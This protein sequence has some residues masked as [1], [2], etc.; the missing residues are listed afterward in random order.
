MLLGNIYGAYH[1]DEIY[2]SHRVL[3]NRVPILSISSHFEDNIPYGETNIYYANQTMILI[4]LNQFGQYCGTEKHFNEKNDL[5]K[6]KNSH[7]LEWVKMNKFYFILMKDNAPTKYLSSADFKFLIN[8]KYIGEK[9]AIDCKQF[10]MISTDGFPCHEESKNG[11]PA[12]KSFGLLDLEN[13]FEMDLEKETIL[14]NDLYKKSSS[15]YNWLQT[16]SSVPIIRSDNANVN[17]SY[18]K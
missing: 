17:H 3:E 14:A 8:C 11:K 6:I 12:H 5:I 18:I 2:F 10:H 9:L 7:D 15:I 16:I 13:G 4:Q 1:Y